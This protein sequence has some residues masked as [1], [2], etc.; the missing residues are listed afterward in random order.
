MYKKTVYLTPAQV[1]E[2]YPEL[3]RTFGCSAKEI[4]MFL[5]NRLLHGHYNH[6]LRKPIKSPNALL[7]YS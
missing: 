4:G 3:E 6:A 5:K 2:K 7:E 1:I